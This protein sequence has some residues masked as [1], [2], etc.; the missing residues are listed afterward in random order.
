MTGE[1]REPGVRRPFRVLAGILAAFCF[2]PA[3]WLALG[4]DR[5]DAGLMPYLFSACGVVILGLALTGS[6]WRRGRPGG[7]RAEPAREAPR[8]PAA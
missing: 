6:A 4:P 1:A 7:H 3:A 8:P 2:I 5:R